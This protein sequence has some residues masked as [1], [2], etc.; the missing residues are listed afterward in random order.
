VYKLKAVFMSQ[1]SSV[2]IP[3][4]YG[5]GGRGSIVGRAKVFFSAPQRPERL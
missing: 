1:K 5:L 2:G 3:E 4:D